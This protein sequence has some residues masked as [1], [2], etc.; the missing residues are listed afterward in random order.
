MRVITFVL[1]AL[2]ILG[3]TH[4]SAVKKAAKAAAVSAK[5]AAI[6]AKNAAVASAQASV[7]AMKEKMAEMI[8]DIEAQIMEAIMA[9]VQK[10]Q[11]VVTAIDNV[12]KGFP[13]CKNEVN[14][15]VNETMTTFQNDLTTCKDTAFAETEALFKDVVSAIT[16]IPVHTVA[17]VKTFNNCLK[18][19]KTT[20]CT[21]IHHI[22]TATACA[23]HATDDY[24]QQVRQDIASANKTF[25]E[26]VPTKSPQ[27]VL[28]AGN[29]ANT[30]ANK[31]ID[32]LNDS[33][34]MAKRCVGIKGYRILV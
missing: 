6:D 5:N 13:V 24:Q 20:R 17:Y 9:P 29:C 12:V 22:V 33:L 32:G 16:D 3:A 7:D 30:A 8:R 21:N 34:T 26:D 11:N 23:T 1:L 28:D 25:T 4:G 18:H 31:A 2:A 27:I 15:Y 14:D 19:T 10:V